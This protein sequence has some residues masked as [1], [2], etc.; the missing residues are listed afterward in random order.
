MIA[1]TG[2]KVYCARTAVARPTPARCL[3]NDDTSSGANRAAMPRNENKPTT[4]VTVVRMMD[5][6]VAGS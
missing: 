5:D 1:K 6:A 3:G 2:V 4:S